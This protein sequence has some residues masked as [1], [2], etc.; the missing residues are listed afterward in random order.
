MK[1]TD[2]TTH[3]SGDDSVPNPLEEEQEN[4]ALGNKV[5]DFDRKMSI[6]RS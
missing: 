1:D 2:K 3:S 4:S 5:C 6:A